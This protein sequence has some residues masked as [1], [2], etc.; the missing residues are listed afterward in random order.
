MITV[1]NYLTQAAAIDFSALPEPLR[2][3]DDLARKA[4][5]NSAQTYQSNDTIKRVVDTYVDKL[6][7]YLSAHPQ[8]QEEEAVPTTPAQ[9]RAATKPKT[10]RPKARAAKAKARVK[11]SPKPVAK[12]VELIPEEIRFLRRYVAMHGKVKTRI[13][14]V[15]L[16]SSLQKA[17]IEKRIRKTSPY[18]KEIMQMQDQLIKAADRMGEAAEINIT[19]ANLEHY[20]EIT[21]S[22]RIRDSIALLKRFVAIHGREGVQDKAER[23]IAAMERMVKSGKVSKDDPYSARL[24]D[25]YKSLK[26]YIRDKKKTPQIQS[27]ELNGIYGLLGMAP[28]GLS[29]SRAMKPKGL[30]S[31]MSSADLV[32]M[33]FDTIGLKGKFRELIGDPSVGFTAMVFGQPKSGKST[34]MLEFAHHLAVHHGEVLYVAF[35][36]GYGYTLKE[37]IT[38]IGAIHPRLNFSETLPKDVAG[39]DFVF[40]DSVSRAGMELEDLVKLKNRYPQTCFV[41]IFHATKDGKFRGGNELAHEVDV[42]IEVENKMATASGRFNAGGQLK[43]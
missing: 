18:A 9:P 30:G 29:Y 34:L 23:L 42:I 5:Q 4:L 43:I 14:V 31:V 15:R 40:I 33:D 1:N 39:Y 28:S 24:N 11:S 20:R 26:L 7:A 10:A 6:N 13:A 22:Q 35:E 8:P 3:G 2:K 16:L 19:K 17:M 36:E 25:A 27:G 41:F 32:R 21:S 12:P 37:K 38:R